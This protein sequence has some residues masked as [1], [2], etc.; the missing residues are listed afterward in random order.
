MKLLCCVS[1]K[2]TEY[3]GWQKQKD[4]P[5]IQGTIENVISK[6]LDTE[7]PIFGSGRTDSKVHA[8]NQYFHFETKKD[9]DL[10]KFRYSINCL[11]PEDIFLKEIKD[12]DDDFH[13]RYSAKSKTYTYKIRFGERNPLFNDL[14][15]NIPYDLDANLL[16]ISLQ[17]FKGTHNFIDFTSKEDDEDSYVRTIFDVE[18]KYDENEKLFE[19]TFKGDGFMRYQIRFMVGAAL[20]VASHKEDESYISSHLKDKAEREIVSYKAEPQGLYLVDVEY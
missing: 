4:A 7:T 11:L 2:G 18:T 19:V 5:S 17:L 14:E 16:I 12:V 10:D 13:A 8:I 1:Y 6:I 15:T 9:L 20:A 3:Q